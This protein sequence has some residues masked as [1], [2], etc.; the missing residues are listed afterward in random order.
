MWLPSKRSLIIGAPAIIAASALGIR[1]ANAATI[2]TPSSLPSAGASSVSSGRTFCTTTGG[3]LGQLQVTFINPTT[4]VCQVNHAAIGIAATEPNTTG[5]T[6]L[7]FS[8]SGASGGSNSGPNGTGGSGI[9]GFYLAASG[10]QI[11]SDWLT[12][13][14][15]GSATS[16][17]VHMDYI[18]NST[19]IAYASS[20]TNVTNT[21]YLTTT[22][23]N[24]DYLNNTIS[25][26]T[27]QAN[28]LYQVSSIATQSSGGG[29]GG[30]KIL[31]M[32]VG[33]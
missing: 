4:A 6:E 7:K 21:W 28:T 29:G 5:I 26:Y 27:S 13:A 24:T 33:Q 16:F 20:V 2:F 9:S 10:G 22:G 3:N 32:G 8:T 15:G 30:A 23:P 17:G 19:E 11:V 25:G 18:N 1:K 31:L 12:F 14:G